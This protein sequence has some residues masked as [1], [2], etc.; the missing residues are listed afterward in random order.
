M[1]FPQWI[2]IIPPMFVE[3]LYINPKEANI[4]KHL[5]R[6]LHPT[7]SSTTNKRPSNLIEG[8]EQIGVL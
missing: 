4:V 3:M 5:V 1:Y 2:Q 6:S 7:Y 8:P